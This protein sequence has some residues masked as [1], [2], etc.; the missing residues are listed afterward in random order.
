M[1]P[2]PLSDYPSELEQ[3]TLGHFLIGA[4]LTA[5]PDHSLLEFKINRLS[6]W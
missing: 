2:H 4:L 1:P 5:L 3:L 6:R